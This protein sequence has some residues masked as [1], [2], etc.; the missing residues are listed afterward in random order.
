VAQH[1]FPA[2]ALAGSHIVA[3]NGSHVPPA[4]PTSL[5][6]THR[7]LANSRRPLSVSFRM[8]PGALVL[9]RAQVRGAPDG[10]NNELMLLWSYK[11]IPRKLNVE[12]GMGEL[13]LIPKLQ[14][15]YR[16]PGALVLAR[17]QAA[18]HAAAH[19]TQPPLAKGAAHEKG[20]GEAPAA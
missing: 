2:G 19:A 18:D 12:W 16:R 8:R 17:A 15:Q 6:E 1:H 3:V 4:S 20:A 10:I 14:T 5:A 13:K 7:W 11:L 9:A